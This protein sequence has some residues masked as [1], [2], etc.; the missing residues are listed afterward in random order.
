MKCIRLGTADTRSQ[1]LVSSIA[2]L[3]DLGFPLQMKMGGT[4]TV[5]KCRFLPVTDEG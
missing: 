3:L 1:D 5:D 2:S 4:C